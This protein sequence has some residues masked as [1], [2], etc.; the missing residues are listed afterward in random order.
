[1]KKLI[2]ILCFLFLASSANATVYYAIFANENQARSRLEE[3]NFQLGLVD[4]N[5]DCYPGQVTCAALEPFPHPSSGQWAVRIDT[6]DQSISGKIN[7][8]ITFRGKVVNI[9]DEILTAAEK[10][11]LKDQA[12]MDANGWFSETDGI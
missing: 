11:F 5:G 7:A 8:D 4:S 12:F 10:G 1:M 9:Y 3:I 2:L 6:E